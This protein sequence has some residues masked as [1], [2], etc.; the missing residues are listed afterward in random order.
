MMRAHAGRSTMAAHVTR[1]QVIRAISSSGVGFA[2]SGLL[3]A[4]ASTETP[5]ARPFSQVVK[6]KQPLAPSA[7]FQLP[8]GSIRPHGWLLEQL[9]IQSNGLSGHLGEIWADVGANSGWLGGTGES[10]ERGPYYLDGLIP[11]AYQLN[12]ARLRTIAQKF[13][14]WTLE[15]V[16]SDGM[17]GPA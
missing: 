11:L 16:S 17:I 10:W 7:F 15:H 8:L 4:S 12:D 13:I 14:D 6:D 9:R 2:L 5:R 3:P 1:R